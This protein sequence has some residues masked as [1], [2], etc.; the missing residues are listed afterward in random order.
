[1]FFFFLSCVVFLFFWA[2][3]WGC[4]VF[5]PF[6]PSPRPFCFFLEGHHPVFFF[7]R[8]YW[9]SRHFLWFFGFTFF[10]I[11]GMDRKL[12]IFFLQLVIFGRETNN[13]QFFPDLPTPMPSGFPYFLFFVFYPPFFFFEFFFRVFLR[14]HQKTPPPQQKQ[15]PPNNKNPPRL[16]FFFFF[17]GHPLNFFFPPPVTSFF[18]FFTPETLTKEVFSFPNVEWLVPPPPPPPPP[19]PVGGGCVPPPWFGRGGAFDRVLTG[20]GGCFFFVSLKEFWVIPTRGG[21]GGGW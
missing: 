7:Y 5:S 19:P 6:F 8:L 12:R 9:R 17:F 21:C 11:L 13:F 2:E 18:F 1:L 20:V 15:Q 4:W 3:V 16:V 14:D 10:S